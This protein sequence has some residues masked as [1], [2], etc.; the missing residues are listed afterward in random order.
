MAKECCDSGCNNNMLLTPKY[1][2]ILWIALLINFTMFVV[3]VLSGLNAH[4]V[5]LMVDAIDFFGDVMNYSISLAV[6]P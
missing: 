3:E 6:F 2:K 5:S 1:R 4:S